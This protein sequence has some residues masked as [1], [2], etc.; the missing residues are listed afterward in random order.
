LDDTIE[1]TAK[2][3]VKMFP[4]FFQFLHR[5]GQDAVAVGA[6]RQ[7]VR[8]F[9]DLALLQTRIV[10]M[11]MLDVAKSAKPKPFPWRPA[12][13]PVSTKRMPNSQPNGT[14]TPAAM[15]IGPTKLK[16]NS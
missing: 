8:V 11:M 5:I 12:F 13:S 7:L 9:S 4:A 3:G 1:G 14:R 10:K 6:P 16:M 15:A 2:D